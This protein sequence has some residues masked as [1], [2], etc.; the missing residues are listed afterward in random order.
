VAQGR[1]LTRFL[2]KTRQIFVPLAA[3]QGGRFCE[4]AHETGSGTLLRVCQEER[5]M[6]VN[7]QQLLEMMLSE[8]RSDKLLECPLLD[9]CKFS[10]QKE[11]LTVK[12]S[13]RFS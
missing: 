12:D 5:S 7:C 1:K 10:W 6:V 2:L 4:Q 11:G 9:H 8:L 13:L 3:V